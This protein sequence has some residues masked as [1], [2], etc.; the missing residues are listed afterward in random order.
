MSIR[1]NHSRPADVSSQHR[2]RGTVCAFGAKILCDTPLSQWAM[3]GGKG[4]IFARR[5]DRF[6]LRCTPTNQRLLRGTS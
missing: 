2:K 5:Q 1:R 4:S 3:A 6:F